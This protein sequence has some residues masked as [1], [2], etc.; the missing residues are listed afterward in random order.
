MLNN[1]N[2]NWMVISFVHT[3]FWAHTFWVF[4]FFKAK[5]PEVQSSIYELTLLLDARRWGTIWGKQ[6]KIRQIQNE[7]RNTWKVTP[8]W[9]TKTSERTRKAALRYANPGIMVIERNQE[10]Q[11]PRRT[12]EKKE[13]PVKP[14]SDRRKSEQRSTLRLE[15]HAMSSG[16]RFVHLVRKNAEL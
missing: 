10:S 13:S 7:T 15:L 12:F 1:E 16:L 11:F 3:H 9:Q 14:R 4:L 6:N 5:N 2:G 8:S